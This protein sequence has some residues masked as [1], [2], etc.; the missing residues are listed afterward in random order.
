MNS[1]TS[2]VP[3]LPSAKPPRA[4]LLILIAV[5]GLMTLSGI[6]LGSSAFFVYRD[7]ANDRLARDEQLTALEQN[8][9]I[10]QRKAQLERDYTAPIWVAQVYDP[11]LT[12]EIEG[13]RAVPVPVLVGTE[14]DSAFC[15]GSIGADGFVQ[16]PDD[17]LC[18]GY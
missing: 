2:N 6:G 8:A 11:T 18:L 15:V 3:S 4:T 1:P 16:N 14:L 7:R 5:S 17:P 13:T 12:Y 9:E 10:S